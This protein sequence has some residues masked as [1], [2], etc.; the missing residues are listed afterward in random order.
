MSLDVI[1]TQLAL[2]TVWIC[3]HSCEL[4]SPLSNVHNAV[5]AVFI[6]LLLLDFSGST[7]LPTFA[8]FEVLLLNFLTTFFNQNGS[9]PCYR[10][11]LQA[12]L[13]Y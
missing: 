4:Q 13:F 11:D 2:C 6:A 8:H 1:S 9:A 7:D 3:R 5:L 10:S 12:K